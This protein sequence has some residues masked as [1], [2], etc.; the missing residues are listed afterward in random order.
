MNF[1]FLGHTEQGVATAAR[2]AAHAA[3]ASGMKVRLYLPEP[4]RPG[5][6]RKA[7]LRLAKPKEELLERGP[8]SAPDVVL[9]FDA[10]MAKEL[11]KDLKERSTLIVNSEEKFTNP[12]L[13]KKKVR[14][15]SVDATG[16]ALS[17]TGRPFPAAPMAGALSK[18]FPKLS[19]KALR[20][21]IEAEFYD[22]I[23]EHQSAAE[24]GCK[25][26]K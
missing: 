5:N 9:A 11:S 22:R 18:V 6:G 25:M 13:A 14:I 20:T 24:Q 4:E 26:A 2:L 12:V 1:L 19:L 17:A 15:V 3:V 7:Y 10:G 16:I 23:A 8:I 21:A